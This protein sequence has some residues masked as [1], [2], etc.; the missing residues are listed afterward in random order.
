MEEGEVVGVVSVERRWISGTEGDERTPN[1]PLLA[2]ELEPVGL[3]DGGRLERE[4][5]FLLAML[6]VSEF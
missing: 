3:V 2:E 1:L 6:K 4:H 5:G